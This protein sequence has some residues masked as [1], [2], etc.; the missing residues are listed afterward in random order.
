MTLTRKMITDSG[1]VLRNAAVECVFMIRNA[2]S[3]LRYS[4]GRR[5]ARYEQVHH[6]NGVR[7]DNRSE[8]L[9]LWITRQPPGQRPNEQQHCKTCVCFRV[10]D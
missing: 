10:G 7:N 5:L 2:N 8:N 1:G 4:L 6:K 3:A 9:E